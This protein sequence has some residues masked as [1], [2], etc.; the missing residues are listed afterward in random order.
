MGVWLLDCYRSRVKKEWKIAFVSAF[1]FGF[2]VHMYLF[3][4][5]LLN[6]D[7]LYNFYSSQNMVGSGRWFLSIACGFS[8]FFNLPWLIGVLS[9]FFIA[10][11]AV[12]IVDIFT[13]ENPVLIIIISGLLT[14]FPAITE[15][16][17]FEFTADGYMI[18]ML[19]AALAVRFSMIGAKRKGNIV[20]LICICLS[21]GIYQA[22]VSFALV[23]AISYFI[24]EVLENRHSLK[25]YVCWIRNQ[26]IVYLGGMALYYAVWKICMYV[27]HYK[28]T[29]YLG[30]NHL[31]QMNIHN[32]V[33]AVYQTIQSFVLFFVEY[34]F[35]E[36]GLTV[37]A[38]LNLLFLA[39][40]A[41]V[42]V[43]AILK[44]KLYQRKVEF[45]LCIASACAIPFVVFIW[46]FVSYG[47][48]Y[49]TRM[50]QSICI[51]YILVSLLA[52]RWLTPKWS[53]VAGVL[54]AAIV[55]N[56]SITANVFYYYMNKCNQQTY[57]AAIEM[58]T[59][60]HEMDDGTIT[61]VLIVGAL[62]TW[63]DKDYVDSSVLGTLGSLKSVNKTLLRNQN[64]VALYLKNILD[65]EL[66]YYIENPDVE[67]P[68]RTQVGTEPVPDGWTLEFPL[69]SNEDAEAILETDEYES[70]SC[71]PASDS[72]KA[73][74]ETI[75]VKLS[76]P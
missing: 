29:T 58:S 16:F 17:F 43:I 11:T 34:N 71:W 70:M 38:I 15:T 7:A 9:V 49:G 62:D 60:I 36:H 68:S 33:G 13:V 3:T 75:V 56:S 39:L 47:V 45:V 41:I 40:A 5:S 53:S 73:I 1:L 19:L 59:R 61:S 42:T 50:E 24:I 51:C 26:C 22:Y 32:I 10:L 64:Y 12:V 28:A 65:F 6:H 67:M 63:E 8:S 35:I 31:G 74:G 2:L 69:L 46:Y 72:V 30:M 20:A 76:E 66:S 55:F 52:E 25:T 37:Y 23:L 48:S 21:C 18:A 54:L 4:N 14:T 57:A 27:Q 44:S